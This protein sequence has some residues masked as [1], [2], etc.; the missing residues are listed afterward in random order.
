MTRIVRPADQPRH[1]STRDTRD[2]RDLIT[3]ETLGVTTL[4]ADII[5]YHP[6]DT[7]AR[8]YHEDADHF[9]FVLSGSGTLH[10]DD[11]VHEVANGDVIHVPAGEIHHFH[12]ATGRDFSFFE[13]WVPSPTKT[14][15]VDQDDI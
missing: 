5:T 15:W 10:A 11:L 7:A 6:G 3:P 8:H 2:R 4:K 12:N 1:A 9:F 13:M 14:V